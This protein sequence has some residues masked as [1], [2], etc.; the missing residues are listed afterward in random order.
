MLSNHVTLG[1]AVSGRCSSPQTEPPWNV[2]SGGERQAEIQEIS[3]FNQKETTTPS[4]TMAPT[5]MTAT[6]AAPGQQEQAA[7]PGGRQH[8]N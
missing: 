6:G 8:V 7:E 2:F 1:R 3:K 5:A 4:T